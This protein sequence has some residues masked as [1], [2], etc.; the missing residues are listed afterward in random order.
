MSASRKTAWISLGLAVAS[1]AAFLWLGANL[2][3]F[4]NRVDPVPHPVPSR[5]AIAL[6]RSSFI[7]DL[8]GDSLM[9]ERDL[10]ERSE[11]GHIDVPRLQEG[12]V[13]LQAFT[14]PTRVPLGFN[15]DRTDGDAMDLLSLAGWASLSPVGS[16]SPFSRALWHAERLSDMAERS[17]GILHPV[18]TRRDLEWLLERRRV[19]PGVVGALLGIEGAHLLEGD[20]AKVDA[21]FDAGYRMIG[22]A[23]F[24][25]NAFAGSAHG[26]EKG[27]L[28]A[29]GRELVA[30]M[31]TLGIAVDLAHVSPTAIRDVLAIATKPLLVSHT[32]VRGTCEGTR[33]L[34]DE[35]VRAIAAG[36]G[37]IG[38]GYWETAVCGNRP[39]HIVAA[40]RYVIDL[41]GG[42]HVGLGSDFDGAILPS[43]DTSRLVLITHRM[44]DEGLSQ[45]TIRK[46]LG[47]NV[48][49]VLRRTLPD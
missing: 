35:E 38:I 40:I 42:D 10:L 8:H 16:M 46:V 14:L 48:L 11:V 31:E 9:F 22:L 6:H 20:V 43:F 30:R 27:G 41:V 49:R 1:G 33:N 39:R 19:D 3:R 5:E 34:S 13:G 45:E 21:L 7:A 18:R 29:R 15:V 36:G 2:E 17:V 26:L 44:L 37:V 12:G 23:H 32:G 28:S 25:D 24:F 4:I 47:E